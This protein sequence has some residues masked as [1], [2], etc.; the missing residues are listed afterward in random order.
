MCLKI[1]YPLSNFV[2]I[3]TDLYAIDSGEY[4]IYIRHPSKHLYKMFYMKILKVYE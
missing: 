1:F 2:D 3:V 4:N